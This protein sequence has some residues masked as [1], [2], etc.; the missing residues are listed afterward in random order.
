MST[1]AQSPQSPVVT[2]VVRG[3]TPWVLAGIAYALAKA[4]IKID[5]TYLDVTVNTVLSTIVAAGYTYAVRWLETF[6]S[7]KWGRLFL[8]AKA[9]AYAPGP[10]PQPAPVI[11]GPVAG[12]VTPLG[13]Q[14]PTDGT[15]PTT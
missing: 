6:K 3:I 15:A 8:I 12:G 7:S 10:A 14:P 9:P 13:A 2:S 5:N 11:T 1:P 4:N